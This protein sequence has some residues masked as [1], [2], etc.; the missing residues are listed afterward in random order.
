MVH[1]IALN[2][3]PLMALSLRSTFLA[4]LVTKHFSTT[5][6]PVTAYPRSSTAVLNL[7][8]LGN[9]LRAFACHAGNISFPS[10]ERVKDAKT[11]L[12]RPDR[13]DDRF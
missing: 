7:R 8:L 5:D 10:Q 13:H 9:L 4:S 3:G 12:G 1:K 6:S 2:K 11:I